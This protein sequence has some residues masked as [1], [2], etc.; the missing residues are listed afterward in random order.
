ML[1]LSHITHT[2]RRAA[3]PALSDVTAE[4]TPGVYGILGPNGS[5]KTTLMNIITDNLVPSAGEVRWDGAPVRK[6]GKAYRELLGYMPQHISGYND[7]PR[8]A[9]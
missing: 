6:M 2:Y 1:T 9:F 4:L 8:N 7:C 5:G 3:R